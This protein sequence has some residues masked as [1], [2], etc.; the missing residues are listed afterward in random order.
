MN[1]KADSFNT[2]IYFLALIKVMMGRDTKVFPAW[3][4]YQN[5]PSSSHIYVINKVRRG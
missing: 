4:L 3:L 5:C 1:L 2:M